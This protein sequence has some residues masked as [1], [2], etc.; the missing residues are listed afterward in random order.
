M[1][2]DTFQLGFNQETG[3]SYV[4][5]A[6]DEKQK[7]HKE[8]DNP[9][10][11]GF[12]PSVLD[13]STGLPHKMCP[14]RSFE[15][16]TGTL[17]EQC[18]FLWQTPNL[19][20]YIKGGPCHYKKMRVG[21]NKL[22]SF[23]TDLSHEANLSRV[24]TNHCIRVTGATN[25]SR[26]HFSAH[27]IMSI[28]G[29]K[30]VNSLAIYQRVKDDEKMMMGMSLAFNLFKPQEVAE[31]SK[32]AEEGTVAVQENKTPLA[33]RTND[34]NLGN[35]ELVP[36]DGIPNFDLQ[37]ILNGI[38]EE[39]MVIAATQV[40]EAIAKSTSTPSTST[41]STSNPSASTACETEQEITTTRTTAI[42]KK[43]PMKKNTMPFFHGCKIG[44]IN[45]HITNNK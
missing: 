7:N 26:A 1:R 13:E 10:I 6:K 16:Y 9:I 41:P 39:E 8:T 18:D 24:Y 11:T 45:I 20:A 15:N 14:V 4:F 22:A 44:A 5:K 30:S 28:T 27:Q 31:K 42:V 25:L 3:M 33:D 19:Q 35:A 37:E 38:S 2:K 21:E 36:V 43:S 17:N 34:V 29:H 32:T 23:M 12:M 40:E